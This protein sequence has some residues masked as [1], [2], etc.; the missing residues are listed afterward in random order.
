MGNHCPQCEGETG[1]AFVDCEQSAHYY[2]DAGKGPG[3]NPDQTIAN[4]NAM[5]GGF[6]P[7]S[8]QGVNPGE[9]L[10]NF[11]VS[12]NTG[13]YDPTTGL[14]CESGNENLP[15][16]PATDRW[17]INPLYPEAGPVCSSSFGNNWRI[18]WWNAYAWYF[19]KTCVLRIEALCAPAPYDKV[20]PAFY[21]FYNTQVGKENVDQL[22]SDMAKA[23]TPLS[24]TC[25]ATLKQNYTPEVQAIYCLLNENN[26][27]TVTWDFSYDPT[28]TS[29][30]GVYSWIPPNKHGSDEFIALYTGYFTKKTVF[31][32]NWEKGLWGNPFWNHDQKAE[33][34]SLVLKN[35]ATQESFLQ[36]WAQSYADSGLIKAGVGESA[37]DYL[38]PQQH[39]G[40]ASWVTDPNYVGNLPKL[41]TYAVGNEPWHQ[42]TVDPKAYG[43]QNPCLDKPFLDSIMPVLV[44]GLAG[45]FSASFLPGE[46][47]KIFAA[48]TMGAAGYEFTEGVIGYEA[49][50]DWNN[51]DKDKKD[52][53]AKILSVGLPVTGFEMLWE[54]NWLPSKIT[55]SANNKYIGLGLAAV[56]GYVL[57]EPILKPAL[58]V[59][60]TVG[61][62]LQ[63]PFAYIEQ[64]LTVLFNGCVSHEVVTTVECTCE[65]ANNKP[66]LAKALV[67]PIYGTTEK[68]YDMRLECMKNAMTTGLWGTDPYAVGS[69]DSTGHMSDPTNCLSA[70]EWAYQRFLV[71][72]DEGIA[73]I[74]QAKWE[75]VS[76]CVAADNP[77][78]LPPRDVDKPCL[79]HG[80]YFRLVNG[81]CVDQQK[82]LGQQNITN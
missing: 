36:Q 63:A 56:G 54:N 11:Q 41:A 72:G 81:I 24:D 77:S 70:G 6:D 82:P 25:Q 38:Y 35:P 65:E 4:Y 13:S 14:F 8:N 57:L 80:P 68:Q 37:T 60:G 42:S 51:Q 50:V 22:I 15:Q 1:A 21:W 67:G 58:D 9:L 48:A 2:I 46:T 40:E 23:G 62:W 55:A 18:D 75:E 3:P 29:C 71:L 59:S 20:W 53:A 76:H 31:D 12:C 10:R 26:L 69:C 7:T 5:M 73:Q 61:Q 34:L 45:G 47:T 74:G 30:E 33:A 39:S 79:Q 78:F 28:N 64:G 66:D 17:L 44:G 27:S 43:Y 49:L 32:T 16:C 52:T 19:Y